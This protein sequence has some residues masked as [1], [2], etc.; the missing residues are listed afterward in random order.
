MYLCL[1]NARNFYISQ[2]YRDIVTQVEKLT[3]KQAQI[4]PNEVDE[5][6]RLLDLQ[7]EAERKKNKLLVC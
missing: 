5:L 4:D 3:T 6:E 1:Y 7:A 2:W